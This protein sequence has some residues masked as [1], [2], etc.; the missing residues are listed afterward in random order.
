MIYYS[1]KQNPYEIKV[2]GHALYAKKGED[3]V[4]ASVST[5]TLLSVN[6]IRR[7]NEQDNIEVTIKDGYFHLTVKTQTNYIKAVCENLI[8]TLQELEETYPNYIKYQ[9]ER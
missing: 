5:A 9:K 6:L 7:L 2:E 8:W 3:I 4:C 1:V